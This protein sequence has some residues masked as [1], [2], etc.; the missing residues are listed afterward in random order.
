MDEP[1][2]SGEDVV[3]ADLDFSLIDKRKRMMDSRGHYS[4]PELLNLLIDRTPAARVRERAHHPVPAGVAEITEDWIPGGPKRC[5]GL[6]DVCADRRASPDR[7]GAVIRAREKL[8]PT[9][10]PTAAI[11][12]CKP[13]CVA[14]P[15]E[16]VPAGAARE[17]A[18]GSSGT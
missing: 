14:R 5:K 18:R 15:L 8:L 2:R 9:K 6:V 7:E 11:R 3:I 17:N 10:R 4:R 13:I 1:L 12:W 16:S